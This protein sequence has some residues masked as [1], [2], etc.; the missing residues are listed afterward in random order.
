MDFR[1][2]VGKL[3]NIERGGRKAINEAL[4]M[5]DVEAAVAGKKDEQERA[6]ILNDLAWKEKLPGLYDPVSKMFVRKQSMPTG[7][8]GQG[9][10]ISQSSPRSSDDEALAKLGLIPQGASTST[11]L[12]R[13]MQGKLGLGGSSAE[14]DAQ[15]AQQSQGVQAGQASDRQVAATIAKAKDLIQKIKTEFP[16]YAASRPSGSS[17]PAEA[18]AGQG[19]KPSSGTGIVPK[20]GG[21]GLKFLPPRQLASVDFSGKIARSL[22]ESFG[23]LFEADVE[24]MVK[25]LDG[26]MQGFGDSEDPEIMSLQQEYSQIKNAMNSLI[27]Q[28]ATKPADKPGE[29]PADKPADKPVDKPV[30]PTTAAGEAGEQV[31][32]KLQRFKDLLAKAKEG[33]GAKP[34][35]TTKPPVKK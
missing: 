25:E 1:E 23:Y 33:Q 32:K 18:P 22:V 27:K 28:Q 21:P 30:D 19:A 4:T 34:A 7:M 2:L 24:S 9:Y 6:A 31:G 10:A 3:D 15:L 12:G 26:I 20:D 29:Q 5:A 8:G 11:G 16:I 35:V 14:K 17:A 13:F